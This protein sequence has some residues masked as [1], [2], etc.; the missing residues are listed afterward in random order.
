[1]TSDSTR[2]SFL[3]FQA[4]AELELLQLILHADTPYP[5]NP[6]E[7]GTDAYFADLEQEVIATGWMAE[8]IAVQGKALA[9][10]VDQIWSAI[11]PV[12][13]TTM[14][15]LMNQL[16]ERCA[17]QIPQQFLE[18]IVQHAHQVVAVNSSLADKLV[19]CVQDLLPSWGEDDLQVLARPFAYAMRG[20]D[21]ETLETTLNSLRH[22]PW[23]ELSSIEQARLSLAIARYA[24]AQLSTDQS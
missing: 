19:M 13:Q 24:I 1:M 11:A 6:A 14:R 12:E 23:D 16:F 4:Q 18:D 21:T 9:A 22:T 5:W 20:A 17:A 10:H 15:S 8:E 2:P 7:L 3:P